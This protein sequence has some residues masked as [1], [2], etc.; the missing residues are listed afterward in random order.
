MTS[1]QNLV[2]LD[3]KVHISLRFHMITMLRTCR[4][5]Y[6]SESLISKYNLL[7]DCAK[8]K[9]HLVLYKMRWRW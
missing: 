7:N 1:D 4:I 3:G 8:V 9:P 2:Q 5:Q 6:I